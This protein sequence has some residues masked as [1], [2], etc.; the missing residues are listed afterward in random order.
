MQTIDVVC[1]LILDNKRLLLA[2]KRNHHQ[3]NP[4]KWEFPGGK[5]EDSETKKNALIREIREELKVEI[6]LLKALSPVNHE[7]LDCTICLYPF[8]CQIQPNTN[9][10]L[11]EHSE[12]RWLDLN[13]DLP[14]EMDWTEAD[15][16][17]L[18]QYLRSL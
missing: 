14:P 6:Q 5:V 13:Q 18:K 4:G 12:L 9:I 10:T 7:Q 16:S 8:V 17:I 15:I 2:C 3:S 1:A 11:I